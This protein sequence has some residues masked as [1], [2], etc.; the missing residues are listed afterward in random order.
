MELRGPT[1]EV[2]TRA[3]VRLG[4]LWGWGGVCWDQRLEPWFRE[5]YRF[6]AHGGGGG[7]GTGAEWA[8]SAVHLAA[9]VGGGGGVGDGHGGGGQAEPCTWSQ[10][11]QWKRTEH[12]G[13]PSWGH[14]ALGGARGPGWGC[15]DPCQRQGS[16]TRAQEP[17]FPLSVW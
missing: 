4:E 14:G 11:T 6:R 1:P 17:P 3:S 5:G 10:C 16:G 13:S 15:S 12:V 7:A 2:N 8:R 9:L